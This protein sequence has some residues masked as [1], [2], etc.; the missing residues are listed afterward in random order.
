MPAHVTCMNAV[1]GR[2][3]GVPDDVNGRKIQCPFCKKIFRVAFASP[4]TPLEK[5]TSVP[6][7]EPTSAPAV[8]GVQAWAAPNPGY[9][10]S[11]WCFVGGAAA[12]GCVVAAGAAIILAGFLYWRSSPGAAGRQEKEIAEELERHRHQLEDAGQKA[13]HD[14]KLIAELRQ[15]AANH[16]FEATQAKLALVK[17]NKSLSEAHEKTKA[18]K[19][20]LDSLSNELAR[21][22]NFPKDATAKLPKS[23]FAL[24]ESEELPQAEDA[25][26]YVPADKDYAAIDKH[27]LAATPEDE[28]SLA[29]L[30]SYLGQP[31]TTAKDK[32]RAIY[33]WITDRIAYDIAS[34]QA[35]QY[36]DNSPQVVLKNRKAVCAGF[37]N[38]FSD[39]SARCGVKA[40]KVTGFAKGFEY[41]PGQRISGTNHD[42]NAVN[43]D[44]KWWLIDATWGA[45]TANDKEAVKRFTSYY[46]GTPPAQLVFTHFPSNPIWQ[47]LNSPVTLAEFEKWPKINVSLWEL[48]VSADAVRRQIMSTPQKR[49]VLAHWMQAKATTLLEAPLEMELLAEK[50]YA[51]RFKSADFTRIMAV[52][53]GTVFHAF[54]RVGDIFELNLQAKQGKL[55]IAGYTANSNTGPAMLE[56][57]VE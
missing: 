2:R 13:D 43:W 47:L 56:Y 11:R 57:V 55:A 31:W 23:R 5:K 40:V 44:G 30:A 50:T 6:Q 22:Q 46:F 41:R 32:A 42:W 16:Q 52:E 12:G 9:P 14:S 20:A 34:F 38:L 28:A 15:Q 4:S 36:G 45:G 35:K 7:C 37:A 17:A 51:F 48:G 21:L 49:I 27:A 29:S 3:F 18:D 26:V 10:R 8:S 24:K 25:K 54:E 1:C 19:T 33:R 39:L 53:N